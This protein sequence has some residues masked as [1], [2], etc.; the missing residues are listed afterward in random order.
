MTLLIQVVSEISSRFKFL[1]LKRHLLTYSYTQD[2]VFPL[3]S[4]ITFKLFLLD[5]FFGSVTR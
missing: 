2:P 5:N 1:S 4:V 3:I